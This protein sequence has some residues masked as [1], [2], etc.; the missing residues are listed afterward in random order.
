MPL[1]SMQNLSQTF[2]NE[3]LKTKISI[4][5][6]TSLICILR[7]SAWMQLSP[8]WT[9][10]LRISPEFPA[11]HTSILRCHLVPA[12]FKDTNAIAN[13]HKMRHFTQP[14]RFVFAYS[15]C[16]RTIIPSH[17]H[18]AHKIGKT[19]TLTSFNLRLIKSDVNVCVVKV[20]VCVFECACATTY[21]CMYATAG[22]FATQHLGCN[23]RKWKSKW[24]R[25][26]RICINDCLWAKYAY[27]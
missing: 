10:Q 26:A 20:N 2:S 21:I 17:N 12:A 22:K 6:M 8:A 5:L 16:T 25:S 23:R 7:S 24:R 9:P 11:Q 15:L 13:A 3:K 4:K 14:F 27:E 19:L 1:K 18:N